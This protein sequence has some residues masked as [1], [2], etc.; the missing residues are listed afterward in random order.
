MNYLFSTFS[1]SSSLELALSEL[2]QNGIG[3]SA[4]MVVPLMERNGDIHII[5][6]K[7]YSDGKSMVDL[8]AAFGAVFML[9]GVIFGLHLYLGP[10][11]WGLAGL[12]SGLLFGFFLSYLNMKRKRQKLNQHQHNR[13]GS[14]IVLIRCRPDLISMA[15]EILWTFGAHGVGRLDMKETETQECVGK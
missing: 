13:Q 12:I 5:D 14:V 6:K 1:Y 15:E 8:A 2:E 11:L 9:L 3:K 10:V 4:I 7:Y